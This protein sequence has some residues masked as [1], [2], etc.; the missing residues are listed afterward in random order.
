MEKSGLKPAEL[1]EAEQD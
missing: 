1:S